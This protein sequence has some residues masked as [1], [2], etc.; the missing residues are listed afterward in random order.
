MAERENSPPSAQRAFLFLGS[1]I[2]IVASLYFAQ[3]VLIPIALSILLTFILTPLVVGLQR[4]GL[5]RTTAV[6]LVVLFAFALLGGL[7]WVATAQTRGLLTEIPRHEEEIK[8]KVTELR[9][10]GGGAGPRHIQNGE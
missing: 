5:G 4:R 3:K 6:V 7:G 2:L 10:S 1:I 9:G 8:S